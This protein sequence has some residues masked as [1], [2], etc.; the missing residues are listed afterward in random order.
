MDLFVVIL[1]L[2]FFLYVIDAQNIQLPQ[3][4]DLEILYGHS[5]QVWNNFIRIR[6]CRWG[7]FLFCL[8]EEFQTSLYRFRAPPFRQSKRLIFFVPSFWVRGPTFTRR[9][10]QQIVS[11]SETSKLHRK[12]LSTL[13]KKTLY[14]LCYS[15][16]DRVPPNTSSVPIGKYFNMLTIFFRM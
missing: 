10:S 9:S 5:T 2:E 15:G 1:F 3:I 6:I 16:F 14:L 13:P 4:V 11:T 7:Y 8:L 12:P